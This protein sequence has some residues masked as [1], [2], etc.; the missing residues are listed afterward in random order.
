MTL[1]EYVRLA[2]GDTE[3]TAQAL[4]DAEIDDILTGA[5]MN[6]TSNRFTELVQGCLAE[7]NVL[8]RAGWVELA[9]VQMD[10]DGKRFG[11][12]LGG[13]LDEM[14]D[15]YFGS[16]YYPLAP[17]DSINNLT[18][19]VDFAAAPSASVKV[20]TYLVDLKRAVHDALMMI[21][22]SESRLAI[23]ADAGG[24]GADLTKLAGEIRKQAKEV[25][26]LP[27]VTIAG[28][29]DYPH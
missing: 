5:A 2:C 11:C 22:G 13:F 15:V 1:R 12:G 27:N 29:E 6:P 19:I 28:G 8:N 4:S 3:E 10:R 17:G 9:L 14:T 25:L 23:K 7:I 21:A 20:R 26:G 24:A 18:G 16:E